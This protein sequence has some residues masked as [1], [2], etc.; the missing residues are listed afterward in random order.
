[1]VVV[2]LLGLINRPPPIDLSQKPI[3]ASLVRLGK[4]RDKRLLPRKDEPPAPPR[5]VQA[6]APAPKEPVQKAP[7]PIATV[8]APSAKQDGKKE[9]DQRKKLFGAFSKAGAKP[10]ELE[11]EEDGDPLGDSAVQEGERYYGALRGQVRRYFFVSET[12]PDRERIRLRA[13]VFFRIGR[14]GEVLETKLQKSSG[15]DLFDSAVMA[16][17]KKAAPFA[18]PPPHLLSSL[19]TQGVLMEFTPTELSR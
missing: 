6:P 12:I 13:H 4:P 17:V 1:V 11:G 10:Q 18:P 16:A 2:V 9:G 5:D 19:R 15:N 3:K 7:S 8:P 14:S